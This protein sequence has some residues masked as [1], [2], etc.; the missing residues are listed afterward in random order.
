[1]ATAA[2]AAQG[3]EINHLGVNNTLVRVTGNE[4]FLICPFRNLTT[5]QE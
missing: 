2:N 3:V 4:Q 5:T 1:M